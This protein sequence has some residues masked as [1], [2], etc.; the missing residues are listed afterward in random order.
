M[1]REYMIRFQCAEPNCHEWTHY[2]ASTRKEQAEIYNRNQG[3]WKCVRHDRPADLLGPTNMTRVHEVV[4]DERSHGVYWGNFGFVSGPGFCAFAKDF[5]P[6][7]ILR[8]TAEV[9]LPHPKPEI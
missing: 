3:K 2:T 1:A 5:P 9:I 4:S 8:V 6:G 7:T